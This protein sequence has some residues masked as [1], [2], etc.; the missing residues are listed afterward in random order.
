MG[1]DGIS[2][3]TFLDAAGGAADDIYVTFGSLFPSELPARGQDFAD[4]YGKRFG[5]DPGP[6]TANGYEATNVLLDAIQRS[7][8]DDGEVTRASVV[9]E[10]FATQNYDGV[11][12][13]RSF[14][15]DGDTDLTEISVQRVENGEFEFY[16]TIDFG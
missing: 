3:Q 16:K 6:Y 2:D 9:Q 12:G 5:S 14:D 7:Y 15:E 8:E 13:T 1:P 4:R 11:L 10:L